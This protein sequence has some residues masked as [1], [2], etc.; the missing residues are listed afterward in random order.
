MRRRGPFALVS[1]SMV[2]EA[3]SED[4]SRRPSRSEAG[5]PLLVLKL[6]SEP[7]PY[8]ECILSPMQI[9]T[10]FSLPLP[11]EEAWP[12]L[13]DLERVAPSMPGVKVDSADDEGRHA[14][15][16]GKVG[17]VTASY[18]T[19]VTIES[20]DEAGPTAVLKASGRETRGPG[21]VE[22]TVTAALRADGDQ[23]AVDLATDLAVTGKV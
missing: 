19:L 17:P 20:L 9:Q 12:L 23:T 5:R 15:M 4:S 6:R 14:P 10:G 7:T 2:T 13:T 11:V 1:T 18:R 3:N 22:A 8:D 21:T 16:R